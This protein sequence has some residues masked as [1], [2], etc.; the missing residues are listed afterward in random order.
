MQKRV[1]SLQ[2]LAQQNVVMQQRDYSCGAAAL[3]TLIR[4]YWGENVGEIDLLKAIVATLTPEQ[5][6]DRVKNGLSMTDLRKAA[7]AQG[8]MASV[9]R[10]TLEKLI[11]VRVPVIVCIKPGKQEHFVVLR[12]TLGDRVFLADPI[13]GNIRIALCEFGQQWVDQAVLVVAK[14]GTDL[15]AHSPLRIEPHWPVQP[16]LQVARRALA[17]QP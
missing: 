3:A 16:E 9:G 5:L 13:R 7:V 1:M 17:L 8:Y 15:P 10:L 6:Q 14:P 4:Y 12:G 2:A 11:A